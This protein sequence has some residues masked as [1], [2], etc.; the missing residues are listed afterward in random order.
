VDRSLNERAGIVE[1]GLFLGMAT[2][3]V[4]AGDDDA[5]VL[6]RAGS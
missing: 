2:A 6:E 1:S 3:V 4:A 5:R